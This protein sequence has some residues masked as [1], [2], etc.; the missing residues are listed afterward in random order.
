MI[1]NETPFYNGYFIVYTRL[2]GDARVIQGL[3][4]VRGRGRS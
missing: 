2:V 1:Y 3:T 4:W